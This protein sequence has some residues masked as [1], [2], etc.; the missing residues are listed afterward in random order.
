MYIFLSY[1][2]AIPIMQSYFYGFYQ[3]YFS[4]ENKGRTESKVCINKILIYITINKSLHFING[5]RFKT[6]NRKYFQFYMFSM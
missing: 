3:N 5:I 2:E 6:N 4:N 1:K